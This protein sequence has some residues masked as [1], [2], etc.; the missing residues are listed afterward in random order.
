MGASTSPSFAPMRASSIF[1]GSWISAQ[2]LNPLVLGFIEMPMTVFPSNISSLEGSIGGKCDDHQDDKNRND[3]GWNKPGSHNTCPSLSCRP[4]PRPPEL[5][6]TFCL[7]ELRRRQPGSDPLVS[8]S[9]VVAMYAAGARCREQ[10]P[11]TG[12]D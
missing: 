9:S 12:I 2:F 1:A 6:Q 8:R 11:G 7:A 5:R 3:E 10:E 4:D